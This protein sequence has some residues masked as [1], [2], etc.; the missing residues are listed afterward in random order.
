MKKALENYLIKQYEEYVYDPMYGPDVY[1]TKQD[2]AAGYKAKEQEIVDEINAYKSQ[3]KELLQPK[4]GKKDYNLEMVAE[5]ESRIR[6][7]KNLL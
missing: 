4:M 1:T 3:I 7:L 5:L 2:F 6:T